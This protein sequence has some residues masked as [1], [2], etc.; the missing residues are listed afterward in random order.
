MDTEAERGGDYALCG[1]LLLFRKQLAGQII[2][3]LPEARRQRAGAYLKEFSGLPNEIWAGRLSAMAQEDDAE[4]IRG[5]GAAGG[6]LFE[7]VPPALRRWLCPRDREFDGRED[8]QIGRQ[9]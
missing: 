3:L 9:R 1:F 4:A 2:A 7:S 8:H 6:G 5:S